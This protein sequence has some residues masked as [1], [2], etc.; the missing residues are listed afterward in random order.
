[1]QQRGGLETARIAR[2]KQAKSQQSLVR[3]DA[4][5]LPVPRMKERT[6]AEFVDQ[7]ER[8]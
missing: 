4:A 1:V 6:A 5:A 2:R 3:R 8:A 7:P